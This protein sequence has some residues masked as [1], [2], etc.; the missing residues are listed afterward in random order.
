MLWKRHFFLPTVEVSFLLKQNKDL[1]IKGSLRS[2]GKFDVS[3]IAS[4]FGGGGHKTRA[5]FVI[6]SK[7]SLQSVSK[8][9]LKLINEEI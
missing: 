8:E 9:V 7:H 5:G 1:T 4:M 6:K 3:R 2:N